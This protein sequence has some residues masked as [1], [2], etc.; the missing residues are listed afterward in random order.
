MF[1]CNLAQYMLHFPSED[2]EKEK[3]GIMYVAYVCG[4]FRVLCGYYVHSC[5]M[6]DPQDGFHCGNGCANR[7]GVDFSWL[8]AGIAGSV[9][10]VRSIDGKTLGF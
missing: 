9:D 7:S 5:K 3:E 1:Q 8:I 6:R 10:Q 2:K 4:G